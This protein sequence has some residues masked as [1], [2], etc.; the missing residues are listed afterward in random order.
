MPQ[1]FSPVV[2]GANSMGIFMGDMGAAIDVSSANTMAVLGGDFI[3]GSYQ[4][5][6]TGNLA[7]DNRMFFDVS[8][9]AFRAGITEGTEWDD[10][11][12]GV[13]S[14]AMGYNTTASADSSFAIGEETTASATPSFASGSGTLASGVNSTAMG[15]NSIASGE[16][17]TA[18]GLSTTASAYAA[19]ALGRSTTASGGAA[20]ATGYNTTAGAYVSTAMG[21]ETRATGVQSR[22]SVWVIHQQP[23]IRLFPVIT[24]LV[25]SWVIRTASASPLP[26]QWACSAGA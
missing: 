8:K 14:I 19:T 17:S 5:E 2:S 20:F 18:L 23:L 21:Y 10:A 26:T 16:S 1:P 3:V 7:Q 6:D 24:P 12:V 22:L 11:N 13:N 25:F 15:D 4:T 9:G